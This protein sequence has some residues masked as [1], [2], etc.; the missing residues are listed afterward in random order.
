MCTI[1]VIIVSLL[2]K[3][4]VC[5]GEGQSLGLG[6]GRLLLRYIRE[7]SARDKALHISRPPCCGSGLSGGRRIHETRALRRSLPIVSTE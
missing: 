3:G 4:L 5:L 2:D 1:H 6:M 7:K